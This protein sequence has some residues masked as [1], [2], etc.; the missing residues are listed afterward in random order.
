M[1]FH[2]TSLSLRLLFQTL[3]Q[4]NNH[5]QPKWCTAFQ[6]SLPQLSQQSW[7]IWAQQVLFSFKTS[8]YSIP[9]SILETQCKLIKTILCHLF[10]MSWGCV[11]LKQSK[12]NHTEKLSTKSQ[13]VFLFCSLLPIPHYQCNGNESH[14]LSHGHL[15]GHM[16]SIIRESWPWSGH[17]PHQVELFSHLYNFVSSRQ[18]S[19]LLCH[20]ILLSKNIES[21]FFHSSLSIT[22]LVLSR[23]VAGCGSEDKMEKL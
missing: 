20:H 7:R 14:W 4:Y 12:G 15:L 18:T 21:S 9:F 2:Q 11:S 17:Y 22:C 8:P 3:P 16:L 13:K 19:V 1:F 6:L 10:I 5:I 23:F